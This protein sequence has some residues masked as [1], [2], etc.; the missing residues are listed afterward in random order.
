MVN[1][2]F[3]QDS[4][5]IRVTLEDLD[6]DGVLDIVM[7]NRGTDEFVVLLGLGGGSFQVLPGVFAG[8]GLTDFAIGDLDE[9]GRLDLASSHSTGRVRI[10]WGRGDGTFSA[11]ATI[12][13]DDPFGF[14]EPQALAIAKIDADDRLDIFCSVTAGPFDST[15]D[16]FLIRGLGAQ[17][18]SAPQ[19][20]F[21]STELG[22]EIALADLDRDGHCDLAA[23]GFLAATPGISIVRGEATG[24]PS[25]DGLSKLYSLPPAVGDW[26]GDGRADLASIDPV[27]PLCETRVEVR[28][29]H[30]EDP[31]ILSITDTDLCFPRQ[32]EGAD[33]DADEHADLLILTDPSDAP[34][35]LEPG[36]VQRLYGRGDGTFDV[37]TPVQVTPGD[38]RLPLR[39]VL[40][41]FGAD[42]RPDLAVLDSQ[43][44]ISILLAGSGDSFQL[45]QEF[46][47]TTPSLSGP[48][49]YATDADGDGNGD[50]LVLGQAELHVLIGRGDGSFDPPIVEA[51]ATSLEDLVAHDFDGD[52][53]V[54]L[55]AIRSDQIF[56]YQGLGSG[57]FQPLPMLALP[58]FL[59][60]PQPSL[61]ELGDFDGDGWIDLVAGPREGHFD[62]LKS[63]GDG[64][65]EP[66]RR[67]ARLGRYLEPGD[68]DGDGAIDLASPQVFHRNLLLEDR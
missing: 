15:R 36:F 62:L 65:F 26:N 21:L 1:L 17:S 55:A 67:Y 13:L 46:P 25:V 42:P 4:E 35:S 9:D 38:G 47:A 8:P 27:T 57:S 51:V 28:L 49:L 66:S 11:G 64:S 6:Q 39:F 30:A 2:A 44:W 63:R 14:G 29:Q 68:F 56:R 20:V 41:D 45:T 7:V 37:G 23:V 60:T 52:G 16:A 3:E 59:S 58:S 48:G 43:G 33:L 34:S 10:R 31:T 12:V 54:D 5:P 40:Q 18:F 50:L 53:L 32:L 61:L 24:F 19:N 22:G